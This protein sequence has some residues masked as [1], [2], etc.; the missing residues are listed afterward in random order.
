MIDYKFFEYRTEKCK[1][2]RMDSR[3]H[4]H[5]WC[6][7]CSSGR[8]AVWILNT[9]YRVY[10]A[11]VFLLSRLLLLTCMLSC[12]SHVQVF[13]TLWTVAH[14]VPLSMG[15]SKQEYWSGLPRLPLGNLP[16]PGIE[17][18]SLKS[19]ALAGRFFTTSA[20]WEA[21]PLG[22]SFIT[23]SFCSVVL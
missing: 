23:G 5:S 12:F 21:Q 14:Q 18:E 11:P 20:V 7:S 8:E 3:F 19:P 10:S 6:Y 22:H 15:F 17:S 16:S 9:D 1:D 4:F 2:M 13:V